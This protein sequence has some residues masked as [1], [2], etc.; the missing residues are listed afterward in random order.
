MFQNK[1]Q[2][3]LWAASFIRGKAFD[4]IQTFIKD[5]LSNLLPNTRKDKT[6]LLFHT[7][8]NFKIK[9]NYMFKDINKERI[10][11]RALRELRQK[12]ATTA[13]SAKFQQLLFKTSQG[14]NALKAQFYKGLKDSVKDKMACAKRPSTLQGIITIAIHINNCL[15]KQ[16]L[17]QRGQY[18]QENS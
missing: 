7:Q 9:I 11:K 3:V 8:D 18:R 13:Y 10:A 15:Y 14:D 16:S 17:K 6:K 1:Q 12:G 2:K 4:Q 5:H